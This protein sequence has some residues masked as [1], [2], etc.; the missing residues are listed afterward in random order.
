MLT[1]IYSKMLGSL[2]LYLI[3]EGISFEYSTDINGLI[4]RETAQLIDER[5]V[6]RYFAGLEHEIKLIAPPTF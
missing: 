5:I 1:Y 2:T 4:V 3:Q 6:K